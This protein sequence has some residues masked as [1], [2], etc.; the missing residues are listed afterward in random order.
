M[1]WGDGSPTR[2]FLY[3]D[4]CVE[5]LVLAAERYDGPEPVNLGAAREIS[6]KELARADRRRHRLRGPHHVGHGEAERPAAGGASTAAGPASSSASRRARRCATGSSGPSPGTARRSR[7]SVAASSVAVAHG[8]GRTVDRLLAHPRAVLGTLVGAQIALTLVLA[9]SVDH[10]GWV[11]FQGGDQIWMTTTGWLVGQARAPAH[12]DRLPLA[13]RAGAR[14]VGDGT[15][16]RAGAARARPRPGARPR[17]DRAALR[18]RNRG[19][20]RRTTARSTG[21]RSSGSIAPFAAIPLFVDRYQER[22]SEQFL[23]QALGLTAM[24]D[25]PSMVVVLAGGPL[26]RALALARPCPGCRAGRPAARRRRGASSL[27]TSSSSPASPSPTSS[28][29]AGARGSR[30]EPRSCRRSSSSSLWKVPRPR[31]DPGVR[32]RAGAAGSGLGPVAVD[33]LTSTATSTSTSST[34]GRRWISCASSSG[35]RGWRSGPRSPGSSPCCACDAA[36]SR[37]CSAA[38]SRR[39]SS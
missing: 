4:D 39:S 36:R 17:A 35:A 18:V 27:R 32:A 3:V 23:P 30:A 13:A 11:W 7:V 24:A 16:V 14:H 37:R 9:L 5:G 19:E 34:G 2:E 6:I 38:G 1:L 33:A 29:A 31:R 20:D 15:D 12:R 22:W 10:N 21:R 25:F 28:P 26:R 8:V